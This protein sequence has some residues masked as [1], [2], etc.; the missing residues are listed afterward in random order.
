MDLGDFCVSLQNQIL[1]N[2]G[3]KMSETGPQGF[4]TGTNGQKLWRHCLFAFTLC[5]HLSVP[6]GGL[7]TSPAEDKLQ[8]AKEEWA[9]RSHMLPL[10]NMIFPFPPKHGTIFLSRFSSKISEKNLNW[11]GFELILYSVF[12]FGKKSVTVLGSSVVIPLVG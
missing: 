2:A 8:A 5:L 10:N 1:K 6:L 12:E 11:F 7:A 4:I 3:M 9:G